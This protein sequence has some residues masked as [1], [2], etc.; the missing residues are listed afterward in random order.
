MIAAKET[1]CDYNSSK[2][3]VC[4][5]NCS[6]EFMCTD[7]NIFI[8]PTIITSVVVPV[9]QLSGYGTYFSI[10]YNYTFYNDS[11]NLT[12]PYY[13]EWDNFVDSLNLV[14]NVSS[15]LGIG[16]SM[17]D[18]VL[19]FIDDDV[20][21]PINL[22]IYCET[23]ESC[24]DSTFE[25]DAMSNITLICNGNNSCNTLGFHQ[26]NDSSTSSSIYEMLNSVNII[27]TGNNSCGN[28]SISTWMERFIAIN[29]YVSCSGSNSCSNLV[30]R[31]LNF[32]INCS[33][34]FSCDKI[35]ITSVS[36]GRIPPQ[37]EGLSTG[38]FIGNL[39][40]HGTS[41][42]TNAQIVE[43]DAMW[44]ISIDCTG[45]NSCDDVFAQSVAINNFT[46]EVTRTY[47]SQRSNQSLSLNCSGISSCD[48]FIVYCPFQM[49][50]KSY[51]LISSP[52]CS[53]FNLSMPILLVLKISI[54]FR[55]LL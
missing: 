1:Y 51:V 31:S 16:Y 36:D 37:Y 46:N 33:G 9:G 21:L 23:E 15:A 22:E 6:S 40:C 19:Q 26:K 34:D 11:V 48:D 53:A 54:G 28:I 29:S 20:V 35:E 8:D 44:K 41:S 32:E 13:D 12:S 55:H 52:V 17:S 7:R 3:G 38:K 39:A 18:M 42:C 27:C 47:I 5:V 10:G 14:I 24:I 50:T 4:T 2:N 49:S 25:L 30:I 43:V 45:D